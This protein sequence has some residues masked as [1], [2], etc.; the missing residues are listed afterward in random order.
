MKEVPEKLR[1]IVNSWKPG[2]NTILYAEV[3]D[4]DMT[5]MALGTTNGIITALYGLVSS[6]A[7]KTSMDFP[8][9]I[10]RLIELNITTKLVG[11]DDETEENH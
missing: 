2:E 10:S 9:I 6:I 7:E 3:K 5:T 4:D 1:P 11:D 8:E